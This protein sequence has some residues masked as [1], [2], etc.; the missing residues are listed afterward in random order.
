HLGPNRYAFSAV[1]PDG[2]NWIQTT[3][4]EGNHDW[5]AWI[6][7]GNTGLD[8]EFVVAGEPFPAIIFGFVNKSTPN[9]GGSGHIKGVVAAAKA[10]VPA[11]SGV[12]GEPGITG[13]KIDHPMETPW[14]S[15]NDLTNGDTAV[16]VGQGNA[17]GAFDIGNVP[18]GNYMLAV[19]DE[20]QNYILA[21]QNVTVSNGE[22]VNLG[23]IAMLGWWTKFDGYIFNDLNRNGVMDW[24]DLDGDNCPD[25]GEGELGVPGLTLTMRKRENSLMDRGAT[26]VT[27]NACG[28]YIME[29][30]YPMTEWLVM[31]AYNDLMYTTGVTYQADNQPEPATVL[32]AGV[33]VSVLPIIGLSGRLDWGVHFYDPTGAN[34]ID[35]RNGGIVG[36]V[37]YD[38]TRNELDAQFAAVEDWQPGVSNLNVDLYATVFCG[39]TAGA[40][41]D[42]TGRYELAADG[43]YAKG[44][45]LNTYVTETW[46]RPGLNDDGNCVPRDVN[47]DR[48]AYPADQQVTNSDIDC[49]E[50]PLMGIQFQAGFSAVDGNYGFGDGCYI[51]NGAQLTPGTFD[52]TTGSCS[53]GALQPLPGGRDYLVQVEIPTEADVF[54]ADA[55][56]PTRAIYKVTREEDINIGNGDQFIPQVP[57]PICAGAL[58]IVDV[59]NVGA[60]NYGPLTLEDPSGNG[61]NSITVPAST[62]TLNPTFE[63]ITSPFEGT[64]KPLCDTKLVPLNNGRSIVPTFNLYTDVQIP[65]RFWGLLVDDL[66]FS[67]NPQ[68][69]LYGEKAGV[70]FAPVGIYDWSNRLDS[71]V[72]SDYIRFFPALRSS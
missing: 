48:L 40:A 18:D 7:E 21:V 38:T 62:P 61:G 8:T 47:G 15:L 19:W 23:V 14:I 71:T 70:P 57:P 64:A 1:A 11:T 2:A 65:G 44:N 45:L 56:H 35:P 54:G 41:C 5:D 20:P 28:Y 58:H 46:Q 33:D 32:G 10:Y 6:M 68:S 55:V 13:A 25:P 17:N 72:E 37:S 69:L 49:L 51:V 52:P 50:G 26:A 3:T 9:L 27:T 53:S 59:E 43:S 60:D 4:L 12:T 31:E 39:T 66:N 34:G 63:D 36:T 67:S 29:N 24:T 22:T 30:A 42:P 16:W